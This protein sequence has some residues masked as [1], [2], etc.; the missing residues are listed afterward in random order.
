MLPAKLGAQD[1]IAQLVRL[2]QL[3]FLLFRTVGVGEGILNVL[4]VHLDA[5]HALLIHLAT[6][7]VL[8]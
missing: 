1:T 2:V 3:A 4:A 6:V 5:A 8:A 7:V